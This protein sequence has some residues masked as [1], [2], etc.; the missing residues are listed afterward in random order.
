M[1]DRLLHTSHVKASLNAVA[2]V[3]LVL[4]LVQIKW[5]K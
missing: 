3:L 5:R 2:T 4:V 1:N